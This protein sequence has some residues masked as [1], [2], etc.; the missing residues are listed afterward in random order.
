M[1]VGSI[2]KVILTPVSLILNHPGVKPRV[3][4]LGS[5]YIFG[6][7]LAAI[8][9]IGMCMWGL[10]RLSTAAPRDKSWTATAHKASM[11]CADL[12]LICGALST[13]QGS[14]CVSFVS[15]FVFSASTL[16]GICGPN[17]NF[18]GNPWHPRHLC[19]IASL[20]LAAPP[21]IHLACLSGNRIYSYYLSP[22][23]SRT[24]EEGSVPMKK[25]NWASLTDQDRLMM[26]LVAT[27]L[28]RTML[29][30]GNQVVRRI[31]LRF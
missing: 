27:L 19:N 24:I 13:P 25:E 11:L 10:D 26:V 7:G 18:A 20:A 30:I 23:Q 14:A 6:A 31:L 16:Q 22:R 1:S 2:A 12:S 28:G 29:H 21:L 5:I 4:Q 3:K 15:G 8:T 9:H 17:I